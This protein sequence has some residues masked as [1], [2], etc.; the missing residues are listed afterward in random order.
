LDGQHLSLLHENAL[1]KSSVQ[2]LE[3]S[4]GSLRFAAPE[5]GAG[6]GEHRT[7]EA[8]QIAWSSV[9]GASSRVIGT[10]TA[11]D[12]RARHRGKRWIARRHHRG[13][14]TR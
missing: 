1:R 2:T 10:F 4:Q 13:G 3:G 14:T 7:F 8:E 11:G 12:G 9:V 6:V 5:L